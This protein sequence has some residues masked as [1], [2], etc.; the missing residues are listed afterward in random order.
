LFSIF[1]N[2]T[3]LSSANTPKKGV[4]GDIK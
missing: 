3:L 1:E 4:I 2:N